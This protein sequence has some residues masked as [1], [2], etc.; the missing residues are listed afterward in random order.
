VK[1]LFD[2]FTGYQYIEFIMLQYI[3]SMNQITKDTHPSVKVHSSA[4]HIEHKL[5]LIQRKA[6]FYMLYKAYPQLL[7]QETYRLHFDELS[8]GIG[9]QSTNRKRL[10]KELEE[11]RRTEVRWDIFDK[12]DGPVW[13]TAGLLADFEVIPNEGCF[14]YSFSPKL[15]K[16]F[17]QPS[18]FVKLN[19]L[20]SKRFRSKH[21]LALYCLALDYLNPKTNY[22][23]KVL[24]IQEI[25]DFLG[26]QKGKYTRVVDLYNGVL[27]KAES[28]INSD[29][30]INIKVQAKRDGSKRKKITAFKIS[31]SIK[32]ENLSFYNPKLRALSGEVT[33]NKPVIE[34]KLEQSENVEPISVQ[35]KS[36]LINDF[37]AE[38]QFV[39]HEPAKN[40]LNELQKQLESKEAVEG[41]LE[42]IIDHIN[43]EF[44]AGKISKPAGVFSSMLKSNESVNNYLLKSKK[45]R[46]KNEL[47]QQMLNEKVLKEL[48]S[49][50]FSKDRANFAK[51]L[52]QNY[53]EKREA[54]EQ[55][56]QN[57]VVLQKKNIDDKEAIL[58]TNSTLSI[59]Y[60]NAD[61]LA[62]EKEPFDKEYYLTS[63]DHEETR[64][65][66]KNRILENNPSLLSRH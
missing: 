55:L 53:E 39:F 4:I 57:N 11:L 18:M 35:F 3:A 10:A 17:F 38:H 63:A 58:N 29:S 49:I 64:K 44:K 43:K 5:S 19:L 61:K 41:L 30:D 20:V 9:C 37:L 6:W 36:Q 66:A 22:G 2:F 54:L 40:R 42:F 12:D 60:S 27:K 59:L 21:A 45:K 14:E 51:F 56:F 8:E 1:I 28:E 50:H 7:T 26:L 34:M 13:G 47:A 31:M 15:K 24:T 32:K 23:E 46:R 62:Y 33:E 16:R 52:G 65:Q 48:E 25:R